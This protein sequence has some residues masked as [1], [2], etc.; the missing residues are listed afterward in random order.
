MSWPG[1]LPLAD[2]EYMV[3]YLVSKGP[4]VLEVRA[5]DPCWLVS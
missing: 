1:S 5:G 4:I 2:T 3:E